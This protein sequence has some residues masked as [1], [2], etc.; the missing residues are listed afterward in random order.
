MKGKILS[1]QKDPRSPKQLVI[2]MDTD[3]SDPSGIADAKI[4]T[5]S[6]H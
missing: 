2:G 1:D 6:S 5:L 3:V 4:M